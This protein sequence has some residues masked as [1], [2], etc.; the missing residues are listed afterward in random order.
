M[1][2]SYT[3]V[4][5]TLEGEGGGE[6]L[7][8]YINLELVSLVVYLDEYTLMYWY[9]TCCAYDKQDRVSLFFV[10]PCY[11]SLIQEI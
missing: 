2:F 1:E 7:V 3:Y 6:G 5:T 4:L 11:Y 9:Y 8:F 10:F